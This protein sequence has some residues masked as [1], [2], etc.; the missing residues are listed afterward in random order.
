MSGETS[1]S[2]N[3]RKRE[4]SGLL[5]ALHAVQSEHGYVPRSEAMAVSRRLDVPLARIF[6]VLT[7]YS[8]FRTEKPGRVTLSVCR[9]TSCHL[10][11]G[12]ALLKELEKLLGVRV[13]EATPDGAF[14][15]NAV[16]CLGCCSGSPALM[17]D[18][19][20]Y[21]QVEPSDLPVILRKH[22]PPV[23]AKEDDE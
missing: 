3:T 1:T 12:P 13:G 10:Q 2:R 11:G 4:D 19:K 15:L 9:G 8:Y 7:F 6:E 20:V 14:Q 16:R 18:G 23:A 5:E 17:V 21:S 22:R